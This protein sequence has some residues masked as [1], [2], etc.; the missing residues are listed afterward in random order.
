MPYGLIYLVAK[1]VLR[2]LLFDT[3]A[4]QPQHSAAGFPTR[5]KWRDGEGISGGT[6]MGVGEG[7]WKGKM[8]GRG[9]VGEGRLI[10]QP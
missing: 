10:V 9:R 8:R 3:P 2:I 7:R 5:D 1:R 6:G 4:G